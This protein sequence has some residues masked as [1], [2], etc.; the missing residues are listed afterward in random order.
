[1]IKKLTIKNFKSIRNI[2]LNFN[3]FNILCG[4]NAS[5]KTA[6]IHSILAVTQKYENNIKELDGD[7][8]KIGSYIEVHNR[9]TYSRDINVFLEDNFRNNKNLIMN[10][11]NLGVISEKGKELN[12]CF[13]KNIFYLSS[14]RIG[15]VDTYIKGNTKF[16]ID[17]L[18]FADFLFKNRTGKMPEKYIKEFEKET[19]NST[20]VINSLF[21][22]FRYWAES[23]TEEQINENQILYTNQYIL[24]FGKNTNT[25]S[26]NT[27]SGFS[28]LLPIIAVCLG[29][30]VID[31]ESKSIPTVIIENPEIY[32]HPKA[33]EK[34]TK[35]LLFISKFTQII[36]ETHSDHILKTAI[37][38]KKVK[39]KIFVFSLNNN[40]E[41]EKREMTAKNFKTKPISYAEVQYNAFGLITPEL[42]IILYGQ[43]HEKFCSNKGIKDFDKYM[44][45]KM[46]NVP[47]KID[48]YTKIVYETLPTYIR[49]CID[50]PENSK[51]PKYSDEE[52]KLSIDFLLSQ[53]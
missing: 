37:E 46:P 26:I 3:N 5:G 50:H 10:T 30:L 27:G 36:I 41:T 20:K 9:N 43:L 18:S 48:N 42:H 2:R 29:A 15:V 31:N 33:Q 28:Y 38:Q 34:L 16:G 13:E 22:H 11:E 45:K 25:R 6:I 7:I 23:V 4:D 12:I 32:L 35:F 52:L 8:I 51:R 49:N 44:T 21:E 39:N 40:A 14:N 47:R 53:L 1:M 24:T 17:G 19:E